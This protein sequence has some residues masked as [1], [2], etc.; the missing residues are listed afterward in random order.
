MRWRMALVWLGKLGVARW[1]GVREDMRGPF[2]VGYWDSRWDTSL[3][4][5]ILGGG[6]CRGNVMIGGWTWVGAL[7]MNI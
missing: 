7:I 4:G 1:E 6:I 2:L 3:E 5:R